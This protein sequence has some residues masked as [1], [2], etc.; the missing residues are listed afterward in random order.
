MDVYN[1]NPTLK[2]GSEYE[3]IMN[4]VK[5]LSK[6]QRPICDF[7]GSISGLVW[8]QQKPS[9]SSRNS[10]EI[11]L[12]INCYTENRFPTILSANDFVKHDLMSKLSGENSGNSKF[13][14]WT[15][16]E[17]ARL[18]ELIQNHQ[19]N[20]TEI[21]KETGRK[22]D[23]IILHFMQ[24]PLRSVMGVH[25]FEGNDKNLNK[26]AV[27]KNIDTSLNVFED[28]TNPLIKQVTIFKSMLDK[29]KECNKEIKINK[30]V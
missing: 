29:L 10:T 13:T 22:K 24:L 15:P 14:E 23:E 11:T 3:L 6:N 4:T 20:W 19:D 17:T 9:N 7:C 1:S 5:I 8:Y 26:S 18:L 25:F 12:C 16:E 27:E 28:S 2:P 21:E 30:K